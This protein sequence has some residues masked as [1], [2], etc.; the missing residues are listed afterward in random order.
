[1]DDGQLKWT[2]RSSWR[3]GSAAGPR[4]GVLA[5]FASWWRA[6]GNAIARRCRLELEATAQGRLGD[7][8]DFLEGVA[9]FPQKRAPKFGSR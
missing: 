4:D 7:S 2:V 6:P 8:P 1:V 9:A 5:R 3:R